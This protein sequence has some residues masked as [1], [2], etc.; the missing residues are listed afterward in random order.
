MI[1][2]QTKTLKLNIAFAGIFVIL[3]SSEFPFQ[4]SLRRKLPG[5]RHMNAK[6]RSAPVIPEKDHTGTLNFLTL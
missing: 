4:F 2:T 3:C 1:K 6:P 5:A